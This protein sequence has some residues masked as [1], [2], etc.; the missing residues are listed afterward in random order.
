MPATSQRTT[1]PDDGR[2]TAQPGA[3][4][5]HAAGA[6]V[7]AS[8]ILVL[9]LL[10]FAWPTYTAKTK[11][12]PIAVAG[13]QPAVAAFE[14]Q[15]A[16]QGEAS[17]AI[18]VRELSDRAAAVTAIEQREVYGA[19]VLPNQPGG[20]VEVLTASAGSAPATQ[21]LNGLAQ[22]ISKAAVGQG[23]QAA[24][25][26]DVVPLAHADSRGAGLALTGLPLAMG[27]MIGGVLISLLVSGWRQRLS[28]I[29][30][31]CLIG[32]LALTLILHTWFGWLP[33][34]FGL[35]WLAISLALGA[36]AAT[37]VGLQSLIGQ[38]GIAVGAVLTLLI[39][40]P[41]SSLAMPKEW[42]P[43]AWGE[44]GQYF[45]PGA[46]GTLL[47]DLSYFPAADASRYWL[48]LASWL[49]VGIA[50]IIVGHHRNDPG[51]LEHVDT[52]PG[53]DSATRG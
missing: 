53:D 40:N 15:L 48:T 37:I 1:S 9:V 42:L 47:R 26:T 3:S 25:V 28:A 24:T 4:W 35:T 52:S 51:A 16:A 30:G 31:Y 20:V 5:R 38:P 13:A 29:V 7:A 36:T 44:T 23:G 2:T 34:A 18:D 8:A 46:S 12:I 14:Q 39:G 21:L 10:A 11:D 33:G 32:G 45:V 6:A 22:G 50:L 17:A 41:L 49:V 27:G 19:I 43:G